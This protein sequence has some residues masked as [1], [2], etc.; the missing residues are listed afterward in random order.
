MFKNRSGSFLVLQSMLCITICV[1]NPLSYIELGT[2]SLFCLYNEHGNMP[3]SCWHAWG[4]GSCYV[5]NIEYGLA[6]SS[7]GIPLDSSHDLQ[8]WLSNLSCTCPINITL[9]TSNCWFDEAPLRLQRW[10]T[11]HGD[12]I[13]DQINEV[14]KLLQAKLLEVPALLEV[15]LEIEAQ[16]LLSETW[17]IRIVQVFLE[18]VQEEM[19]LIASAKKSPVLIRECCKEWHAITLLELIWVRAKWHRWFLL[20]DCPCKSWK[21]KHSFENLSRTSQT[22]E[23]ARKEHN[24]KNSKIF[25]IPMMELYQLSAK[26]LPAN[27]NSKRLWLQQIHEYN[28]ESYQSHL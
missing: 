23:T 27:I 12:S 25:K 3:T 5:C 26:K 19:E 6:R 10:S 7:G 16:V 28:N 15:L 20:L 1:G 17:P 24:L 8:P 22:T 4:H 18:G 2:C 14:L 13:L 11:T 9:R 21:A